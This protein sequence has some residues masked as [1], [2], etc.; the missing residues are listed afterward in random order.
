L[1]ELAAGA[2]PLFNGAANPIIVFRAGMEPAAMMRA[3]QAAGV[4]LKWIDASGTV[5]A[6]DRV[7]WRGLVTLHAKG[8]MVV[9]T[10]PLL[11][12]CLAW[13]DA[14]GASSRSSQ[15]PGIPPARL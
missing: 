2:G 1:Q 7:S 13:T 6:V 9:S 5:W 14:A 11:A 4:N 3:I 8:A 10:T 12:G 15:Q